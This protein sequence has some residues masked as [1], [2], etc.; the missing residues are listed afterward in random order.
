MQFLGMIL[1]G[2]TSALG[3]AGGA[4]QVTHYVV[5]F[6]RSRAK[7]RKSSD[8]LQWLQGLGCVSE[9]TVRTLVEQWQP[10]VPVAASVREELIGL[11]TNLVRGARFHTT[12][13]TASSAFLRC[14][15]LIEQLLTNVIPKRR[16][17]EAVCEGRTNW[18][19]KR[20]L[21]MG[22]F[23]EVW[24]GGNSRFPDPRA[25]KF[26]TEAAGRAW[27]ENEAEALYHI[28]EELRGCPNVI[29]YEDIEVDAAPHPFLVLEYVA[30][31]SLEDWILTPREERPALSPHGLMTG[32]A[33]GLAAAHG[34]KIY[35]RDLKP[36]NVLLTDEPDPQPKI[37]DFGLGRVE[38]DREG[39]SSVVSQA[40]LV[41]TRM[42][43]PPEAAD[44]YERRS[45]AQDDVFAFG[46][47]WYQVLTGRI[48]RPPYDFAGR[49]RTAGADT[50]STQL[51]TRCLAHP[52]ERF[53]SGV[54][55]LAALEVETAP[56]AWS[57]PA[58]CFDVG[59]LA[60]E[61]VDGLAR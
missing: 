47:V 32:I 53:K 18:T 39:A 50:R 54:E 17:G 37:S 40:A 34:S 60:R 16:A 55:L 7:A 28:R 59:A 22:S 35:H 26:F 25:F 52:G 38:Q 8:V 2:L 42:Y 4:I 30:G 12:Q 48:E 61:Y 49:L 14:E 20:F 56:A 6:I 46:V 23:G 19:L 41:G 33:R 44:P 5:E 51:L 15:R 58:G 43:L 27:L 13:G 10:G 31:G 29:G 1:G 21:G 3:T 36:A 57:I 9:G 11:L 45:P 24:L